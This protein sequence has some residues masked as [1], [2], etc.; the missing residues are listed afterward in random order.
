MNPTAR[1]MGGYVSRDEERSGAQR[2]GGDSAK[3]RSS[4]DPSALQHREGVDVAMSSGSNCQWTAGASTLK[5]PNSQLRVNDEL[6]AIGHAVQDERKSAKA[7]SQSLEKEGRSNTDSGGSVRGSMKDKAPLFKSSS[8]SFGVNTAKSRNSNKSQDN[9]DEELKTEKLMKALRGALNKLTTQNLQKIETTVNEI[10]ALPIDTN[11]RLTK[12]VYQIFSRAI[13]EPSFSKHYAELCR[14]LSLYIK[15]PLQQSQEQQG[16]QQQQ[17]H[18]A[19]FRKLLL[20]KCQEEFEKNK[21]DELNTEART[22]EIEKFPDQKMKEELKLLLLEEERRIRVKKVG[23]VKFIGELYK[24]KMI[25]NFIMH[26]CITVLLDKIDEESLECVCV[27]LKTVGKDLEQMS[28]KKDFDQYFQ[29]MLKLRNDPAISTRI[30]YML[31]DVIEL[32][33]RNWLPLRNENNPITMEPI[34][35]EMGTSNSDSFRSLDHFGDST[36]NE[37]P[38]RKRVKKKKKKTQVDDFQFQLDVDERDSST[39][40]PTSTASSTSASI[41]TSSQQVTA[42]MSNDSISN[43]NDPLVVDDNQKDIKVPDPCNNN[44]KSVD[45]E[46]Q[47]SIASGGDSPQTSVTGNVI[48][49]MTIERSQPVQL[50]Y[51]YK[52]ASDQWSPLNAEGKKVYDEDFLLEVSKNRSAIRKPNNIEPDVLRDQPHDTVLCN[53]NNRRYILSPSSSLSLGNRADVIP[54]FMRSS[55]NP[56]S[57]GVQDIRD[58]L[59][60]LPQKSETLLNEIL[61]LPIDSNIKLIKIIDYV[62]SKA[63]D[64]FSFSD[65]Y[66]ELCKWLSLNEIPQWRYH[67]KHCNQ[68]QCSTTFRKLLLNKCQEEFE[69]KKADEINIKTMIKEINECINE[70]KKK[71]LMLLFDEEEKRYKMKKMSLIRFIGDL[72]KLKT[73]GYKVTH[74]CVTVILDKINEES[75]ESLCKLLTTIGN[76]LEL[77]SD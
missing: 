24:L 53:N 75:L 12:V 31:Q 9:E 47:N 22:K 42:P 54:T 26:G 62:F 50:M 25:T 10:L 2:D 67:D 4:L 13:S 65:E 20:N 15:L 46:T 6:T 56:R 28:Y 63:V 43:S 36:F 66:A 7:R 52:E 76:H 5:Y 17:Q 39:S 41:L 70:E 19:S 68:Q 77:N 72:Y 33:L 14:V 73:L 30:R 29:K 60:K 11:E 51:N 16:D 58:I 71:K 35:A 74:G 37:K 49:T 57:F 8:G 69:K 23:L 45:D 44:G 1:N 59:K 40:I 48:E 3:S 55:Q 61:A 34:G 27:L 32:R 38:K 21:N 18:S 64:E